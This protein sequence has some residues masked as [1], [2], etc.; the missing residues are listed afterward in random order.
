MLKVKG[1]IF[2]QRHWDVFVISEEFL[3]LL[4]HLCCLL[5]QKP[6]QGWH[7]Q[8][9]A[10]SL[11][12]CVMLLSPLRWR[13]IN[14]R[15]LTNPF[16][17]SSLWEGCPQSF[18][19]FCLFPQLGWS[20]NAAHRQQNRFGFLLLELNSLVTTLAALKLAITGQGMEKSH[21]KDGI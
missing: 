15:L 10:F 14:E 6:N 21:C 16:P 9:P 18:C 20:G 4:P 3:I 11:S 8:L 1:S 12:L 2:L 17:N 5:G 7:L 19:E 13:I